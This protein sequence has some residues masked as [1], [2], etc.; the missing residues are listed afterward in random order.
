MLIP[1]QGTQQGRI[2]L[3][4]VQHHGVL[5]RA[6]D[7]GDVRIQG[8]GDEAVLRHNL[9][10]GELHV[11]GGEVHAVVPLH[12]GRQMEGIGQAILGNVPGA[13]QTGNHLGVAVQ[14]QQAVK[15]V[16]M[17]KMTEVIA[18]QHGI[19]GHGVATQAD[20]KGLLVLSA[21]CDSKAAERQHHGQENAEKP[22]HKLHPSSL[23][24]QVLEIY[25]AVSR[26]QEA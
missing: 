21:G 2:G 14:L 19:E 25:C 20:D 23:Y 3:L 15:Y 1:G 13:G 4:H 6:F 9:L 7:A 17:N 10:I 24:H 22:F 12:A 26:P 16:L 18:L 5:V 8:A 11:L